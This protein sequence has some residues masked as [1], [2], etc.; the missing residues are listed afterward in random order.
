[1]ARQKWGDMNGQTKN[2][3]DRTNESG[4]CG[5]FN[6]DEVPRDLPIGLGLLTIFFLE[7]SYYIL[8]FLFT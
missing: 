1:M 4:M 5:F 8:D 3:G 6:K 7:G 2:L